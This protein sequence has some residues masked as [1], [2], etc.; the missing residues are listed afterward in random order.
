M[1][2]ISAVLLGF[3]SLQQLHAQMRV[4]PLWECHGAEALTA[5]QMISELNTGMDRQSHESAKCICAYMES[6]A[7]AKDQRALPVIA[8]Y[9]DLPNPLTAAEVS[10]HL[11]DLHFDPFGDGYPASEALLQFHQWAYPVLIQTIQSEATF[12]QKSENALEVIM[13]I[14][15]VYPDRAIKMLVDAAARTNGNQAKMLLV[16]ASRASAK[17]EC[18]RVRPACENVAIPK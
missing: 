7:T 5:E 10:R 1:K 4:N 13:W 3:L 8:R 16:A 14:G 6:L 11:S 12:T 9:L 2:A 17:W 15:A 18:E